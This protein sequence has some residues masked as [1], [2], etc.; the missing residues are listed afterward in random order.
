VA[1]ATIAAVDTDAAGRD[2]TGGILANT[3][4]RAL[5]D[6][7]SKLASI[8][9]YVV[10]ARELGDAGFGVFTFAAGY[11]ALFTALARFG[12][13]AVLVRDVARDRSR[14][15]DYFGDT[16]ALKLAL[17]VPAGL[18]GVGA[19]AASGSS[20]TTVALAALLMPAALA[21]ALTATPLAVYQAHERL[22]LIPVVL[23]TQR[24]ATAA[25][26]IAI[27][28]AGA[29][30]VAVGAVYLGGALLG[31]ALALRLQLTRVA[32][33][34][35]VVR[36]SR[37]PALLRAAAP[38][39][40]A[41]VLGTV[42]FRVDAVILAGFEP[43]AVV[44]DYGA[45]YRLFEA[46]LFLGWAVGAAVYPV[47]SRLDE[48]AALRSA[49]ERGLTLC[50]TASLPFAVGAA[51]ASEAAMETVYGPDF[52]GGA[53]AL[54]LLA[55]G[56]ALFPVAYVCGLL[57][58]ARR[59][60]AV[61]TVLYGAVAAANIGLNFALI[62]RLS[63]DG[64]ALVTSLSELALAAVLLVYCARLTRGLSWARVAGPPLVAAAAAAAAMLPL[65]DDFW[66]ATAAGGL[67][68]VAALVVVE[69]I[70]VPEEARVLG[71]IIRRVR[72][73]AG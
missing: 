65:R 14:L 3:A 11:V 59:R 68:Y 48:P 37:W 61:V 69:R 67:V 46:T 24:F 28:L 62:P 19:L 54:R 64:A 32:A 56:I 50:L 70:A 5:A 1:S 71:Q 53:D 38:L 13:D 72:P 58:V 41:G 36:P 6:V 21:E 16:L 9:L 8:A 22:K 12:Q 27:L 10:M 35:L 44:G 4:W 43:S 23:I 20:S 29:S 47:F 34:G 66:I 63:L 17:A 26:G 25:V 57:L 40:V 39:G 60:Q 73:R 52:L 2:E 49:L 15:R 7:G 18:L 51:V 33:P 55:P 42:L 45:A 31:L 30:V